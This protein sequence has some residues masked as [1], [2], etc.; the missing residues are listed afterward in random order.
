MGEKNIEEIVI[1][2]S[3][4][5]V[6]HGDHVTLPALEVCQLIDAIDGVVSLGAMSGKI[7]GDAADSVGSRIDDLRLSLALAPAHVIFVVGA[8]TY[9]LTLSTLEEP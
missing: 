7:S 2:L 3:G 1:G 4:R 5:S 8:S 6:A 9:V